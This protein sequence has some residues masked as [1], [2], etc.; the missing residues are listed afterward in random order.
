[1]AAL[2]LQ[3]PHETAR[4]LHEVD[5]PGD[6]T[7]EDP[8]VTVMYLGSDVPVETIAEMLPILY[9]VTSKTLPFSVS[10][11]HVSTFP[12]GKDGVPVIAQ[13]ESK[14]LHELNAALR[15]AFDGA[16]IPYDKKFPEFKP[17]TTLAYDPNHETHGQLSID[18]PELSWGAHELV[19]WGSDRG[20]GRLV[21]TFPFSFSAVKVA[22]LRTG[23]QHSLRRA[24]V[25]LA[26]WKEL[27]AFV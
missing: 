3:I 1:M 9:G 14:A 7:P 8:H 24:A 15:S 13:I 5:V 18:I 27:H 17:H 19:L 2:M 11:K 21:V 12:P 25:R 4:I 26:A 23:D 16:G 22:S 10:T 6:K 20:T